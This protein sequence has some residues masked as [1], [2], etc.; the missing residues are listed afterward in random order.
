MQPAVNDGTDPLAAAP[1]PGANRQQG[2][3]RMPVMGI[4]GADRDDVKHP[5]L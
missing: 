4:H 1:S 5:P 2:V 3:V